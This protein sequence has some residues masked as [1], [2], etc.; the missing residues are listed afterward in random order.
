MSFSPWFKVED[1]TPDK[2]EVV[3]MAARLRFKDQ[4]LVTGKLIRLWAWANRNS[5]DGH[6]LSISAAFID[7]LTSCKGFAAALQSVGWLEIG[8]DG[9]LSFPRFDRHNGDSAKKR[10]MEARKKQKQR[11]GDKKPGPTGTNVPQASGQTGGPEEE[12]DI[13]RERARARGAEES[14]DPAGDALVAL[15]IGLRP[16]WS[17]SPVLS[18][19]EAESFE[20]SRPAMAGL[21]P[22]TWEIMRQFLAQRFPEGDARFQPRRRLLAIQSIGDVA[23]QAVSWAAGR[24]GVVTVSKPWPAGFE[25]W[26]RERFPSTP[27]R[28]LWLLPEM[29]KQWEENEKGGEDAA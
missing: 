13:R 17:A 5:V 2:P 14:P 1:N 26:A 3:A 10:A 4:D 27:A 16:E 22:E 12:I 6:D 11:G 15:L 20:R 24:G 18:A 28:A 7:R 8:G 21:L 29:R 19:A 23:A 25:E 9:L